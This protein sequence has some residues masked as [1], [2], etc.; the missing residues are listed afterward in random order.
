MRISYLLPTVLMLGATTAPALA[1]S[2]K[3]DITTIERRLD[4]SGAAKVTGKE[5]ANGATSSNSSM[6]LDKAPEGKPSDPGAK[7]TAGGI[8]E[9]RKLL[10]TAKTQD[11]A[12]DEKAC[13]DTITQVKE[14]AG[15]LP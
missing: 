13:Q 3:D 10:D 11:K 14:K 7:P 4:S 6:A 5:P 8:T 2:C 1:I 12:G 9:A 15:A